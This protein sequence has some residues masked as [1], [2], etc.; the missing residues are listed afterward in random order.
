MEFCGPFGGIGKCR[1]WAQSGC[2]TTLV[3]TLVA[4]REEGLH[5]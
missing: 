5:I 4:A 3:E 1:A 2:A